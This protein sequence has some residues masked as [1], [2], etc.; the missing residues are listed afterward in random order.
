[1]DEAEGDET[2]R[3]ETRRNGTERNETI[4]T[5]NTYVNNPQAETWFILV[6]VASNCRVVNIDDRDLVY[7]FDT[8]DT[9]R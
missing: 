8:L 7:P 1:M 9:M 5:I 3:D 2:K 6:S 4:N